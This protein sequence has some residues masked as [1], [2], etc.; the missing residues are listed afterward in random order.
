M[1]AMDYSEGGLLPDEPEAE[2]DAKAKKPNALSII[3]CQYGTDSE[4]E[5]L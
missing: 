1:T 2:D 5:V 3:G 4:A